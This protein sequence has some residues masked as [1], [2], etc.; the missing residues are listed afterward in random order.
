MHDAADVAAAGAAKRGAGEMLP[1]HGRNANMKKMA[2]QFLK[3][4]DADATI[5][6][7]G[8]LHP[9]E[10]CVLFVFFIVFIILCTVYSGT[11]VL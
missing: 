4:Q 10:Q 2:E 1:P 5:P 9:T 7:Q 8:A 3:D 11:Q 6:Q